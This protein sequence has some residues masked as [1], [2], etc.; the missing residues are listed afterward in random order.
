MTR[1]NCPNCKRRRKFTK[2]EQ[3]KFQCSSCNS[4][5]T[6]CIVKKC[7]NLIKHRLICKECM[8]DG[9]KNGGSLVLSGVAAV[10]L[11]ALSK[12]KK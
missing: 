11:F 1:L 12:L 9:M 4:K 6:Q 7:K 10:G 8:G 2:L 3:N 5:Y